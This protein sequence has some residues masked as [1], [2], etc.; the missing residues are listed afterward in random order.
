MKTKHILTALALP[1]MFAACTA[2]DIVSENSSIQQDRAKLSENFAL[3]VG[4]DGVE[5]RYNANG[6]APEFETGDKIGAALIDQY[7]Y[8]TP[9]AQWP[10]ISSLA[11]NTPFTYDATTKEWS[12]PENQPMGIGN[13]FF[14]F[15]YS[16]TDRSRAAVIY[17]LPTVQNQYVD[18]DGEVDLDDVIET[19]NMAIAHAIL[20][21]DDE[22]GEISLK[23]IFTYPKFRIQFDNGQKVNTVSKVVLYSNSDFV[24]GSGFN[25]NAV[26]NYF[27]NVKETDSWK[28]DHYD[29]TAKA[30]KWNQ[31]E[32][33]DLIYT[34]DP[35]DGVAKVETSKYLVAKFPNDAEVSYDSNTENKYIDVRFVLPAVNNA[36]NTT[37]SML[38]YTDNGMYKYTNVYKA[39]EFKKTTSS[40][41]K[42]AVFARNKN[43][44]LT[45]EALDEVEDDETMIVASKQDWNEIVDVYGDVKGGKYTVVVVGDEFGFDETTEMPEV[46]TIT[47][48]GPAYVKGEA[49]LSN[50]TVKG[51][52]YVEEGAVLTTS[53]TFDP[54]KP[55]VNEGE[56]VIAQVLDSKGKVEEYNK[57]ETIENNGTLTINEDTKATFALKNA[58]KAVVENNGEITVTGTSKGE[59][60]N[61]GEFNS[62]GFTIN[63]QDNKPNDG[64]SINESYFYNNGEVFS[65][66]DSFENNGNIVNNEDAVMTCK[67]QDGTIDNNGE[68]EVVDGSVTY[69][70]TNSGNITVDKSVPAELVVKNNTGSIS[71]EGEGS[72]NFKNSLVNTL[73]VTDDVTIADKGSLTTIC[74]DADA[75]I[76]L[77]AAAEITKLTVSDDVVASLESNL[78]VTSLELAKGAELNIPAGV[79]LTVKTNGG[80]IANEGTIRVAGSFYAEGITAT[81]EGVGTIKDN[82]T[83][84]EV[85]F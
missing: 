3:V 29:A 54:K 49:T 25:H 52:T 1:A 47:I 44:N 18:V 79:K 36:Q 46:A 11:N 84:A 23:N 38:V 75:E 64:K 5:S 80:T 61:N 78:T 73:H 42:E 30:T 83:S 24:V 55:I 6:G 16:N 65:K 76:T 31:V 50:I 72:L 68:L 22:M 15:P 82:G 7:K 57:I 81:A 17:S 20:T 69:I 71:Y 27:N 85:K 4:A 70:T 41:V 74:V 43:Y 48:D 67:N 59:I 60:T 19:S 40:E 28:N 51:K 10:I 26:V 35:T 58:K 13:Y 77:P 14:K 21:E 66:A 39:I 56:V 34:T 8:N 37:Y 33:Y 53:A 12:V 62:K 63:F 2:E 9:V 45:L 32:T